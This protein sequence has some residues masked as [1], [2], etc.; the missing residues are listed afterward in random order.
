[1]YCAKFLQLLCEKLGNFLRTTDYADGR[2]RPDDKEQGSN[3]NEENEE[4]M[5]SSLSSER[6]MFGPAAET[7]RRGDCFPASC[8]RHASFTSLRTS[9][10]RALATRVI[11]VI[12]GA[13]LLRR[14]GGDDFFEARIT[15]QRVPERIQFQFAIAEIHRQG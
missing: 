14:E 4:P 7:S 15:A 1:M 2:M 11:R 9:L 13:L 10:G 12:R 8:L 3:E 6:R 5:S